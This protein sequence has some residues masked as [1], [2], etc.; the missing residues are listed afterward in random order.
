MTDAVGL[1]DAGDA[2]ITA[3][4]IEPTAGEAL[5]G[6]S[7]ESACLNCGTPLLGSHCHQ[8]GQAAHVHRTL[9]AFFH[10]LLHGVF[11]FEGKIWHTLPMLAW[12]PGELTRRY[13]DGQRARFVSPLALFLFSVFLLFAV[14]HQTA[15]E[16]EFNPQVNVTDQNGHTI[17][18]EPA[19]RQT[20]A[21]LQAERAVLVAK[22]ADTAAIDSKIKGQRGAIDIMREVKAEGSN[23]DAD[24]SNITTLNGAVKSFRANP[25][26]VAYKAQSYAYK[27]LSLIHI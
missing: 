18:G 25:G 14:Y 27:Y 2:A 11:H 17:A 22:G 13:I 5:E 23:E 3:R 19:A 9:A 4:V 24:F 12:R 1:S 20:L 6:H 8:C 26:L 21:K 16:M 15:G 7:R 10:D